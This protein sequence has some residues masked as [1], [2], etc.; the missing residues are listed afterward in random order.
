MLNNYTS[1]NHTPEIISPKGGYSVERNLKQ[2]ISAKT[3]NINFKSVTGQRPES[4]TVSDANNPRETRQKLPTT[5]E[6]SLKSSI[7][8]NLTKAVKDK[9]SFLSTKPSE[10][11]QQKDK[12]FRGI[13]LREIQSSL[14]FKSK[15]QPGNQQATSN[16]KSKDHIV[17]HKELLQKLKSRESKANYFSSRNINQ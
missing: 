10:N 15:L 9:L 11:Q 6:G 13:E 4:S 12:N 17:S 3:Q 1:S 2:L 7:Q 16:S 14:S 8:S 5:T